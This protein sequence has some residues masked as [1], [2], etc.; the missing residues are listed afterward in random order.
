MEQPTYTIN[1]KIKHATYY[2][3]VENIFEELA[4]TPADLPEYKIFID[5]EKELATHYFC[6]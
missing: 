3:L 2:K 1:D 4:K 6:Y 5:G